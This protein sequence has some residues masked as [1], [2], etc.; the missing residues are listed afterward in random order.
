MPFYRYQI[1]SK[2]PSAIVLA[3]IQS[4]TRSKQGFIESIKNTFKA[5][6]NQNAAFIGVVGINEFN[7]SRDIHYRNS[8]LPMIKGNV[9]E[10]PSGCTIKITMFMHPFVT[11]FMLLWLFM[12]GFG[13][14][15]A[16]S[17][18][19]HSSVVSP[20][21]MCT[22]AVLLTLIGFVPEVIKAKKLINVVL[23]SET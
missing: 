12:A 3:R 18:N 21:G 11:I 6:N 2:L 20:I 22:F 19:N 15:N 7:I 8:F 10:T 16:A 17:H 1:E 4:I 14:F 5:I 9:N 23:V 13:G